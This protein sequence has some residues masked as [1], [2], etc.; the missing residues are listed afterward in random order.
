MCL[1]LLLGYDIY[2]HKNL[3]YCTSLYTFYE[4]LIFPARFSKLIYLFLLAPVCRNDSYQEVDQDYSGTKKTTALQ[5]YA[6]TDS[7]LVKAS[8]TSQ[9][10]SNDHLL[11]VRQSVV[12]TEPA[13]LCYDVEKTFEELRPI[14]ATATATPLSMATAFPQPI[15]EQTLLSHSPLTVHASVSPKLG[16]STTSALISTPQLLTT[17]PLKV[18]TL[19]PPVIS[20]SLSPS[21]ISACSQVSQASIASSSA[22]FTP[23]VTISLSQSL[24][25]PSKTSAFQHFLENQDSRG[26]Q[27][28]QS[29]LSQN[30]HLTVLPRPSFSLAPAQRALA[31]P[32]KFTNHQT[33]FL[34][35]TAVDNSILCT[36]PSTVA[37]TFPF[38]ASVFSPKPLSGHQL[39]ELPLVITNKNVVLSCQR[40]DPASS[41][42][43]EQQDSDVSCSPM[44][45]NN[46]S[47][48]SQT[49]HKVSV[50]SSTDP[51][52]EAVVSLLPVSSLSF[53]CTKGPEKD[54]EPVVKK[55][56][57]TSKDQATTGKG[58]DN[59]LNE[60]C[61]TKT[62]NYM[63]FAGIIYVNKSDAVACCE[64]SQGKGSFMFVDGSIN[65]D[66]Q[67]MLSENDQTDDTSCEKDAVDLTT[68]NFNG[69]IPCKD[70]LLIH[71]CLDETPQAYA[72]QH[73]SSLNDFPK[74]KVDF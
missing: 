62:K 57:C 49:H 32:S 2:L 53:S 27:V 21:S 46:V 69:A 63:S 66:L 1:F 25:S 30:A 45:M 36:F 31:A 60:V 39:S 44:K 55:D 23:P 14:P 48:V 56:I 33:N 20:L 4:C 71:N 59:T 68:K 52:N 11:H 61:D 13:K 15:S 3:K 51:S 72:I 37:P 38:A 43:S 17:P 6:T 35:D 73:F 54:I 7:L 12:D 64:H 65:K 10:P 58:N 19:R 67:D 74:G 50:A 28:T 42:E 29:P 70:N 40:T 47:E 9:V 5:Q 41:H 26:L 22:V 18:Q 34:T 16:I 8:A 24:T